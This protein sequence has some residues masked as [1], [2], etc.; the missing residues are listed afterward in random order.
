MA[1]TAGIGRQT[2]LPTSSTQPM[3]IIIP[4]RYATL[5]PNPFLLCTALVP[6]FY[7]TCSILNIAFPPPPSLSAVMNSFLHSTNE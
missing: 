1:I 4:M 2:S 5:T 7:S 3:L 6:T